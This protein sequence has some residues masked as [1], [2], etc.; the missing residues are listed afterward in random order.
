VQRRDAPCT[1][2]AAYVVENG[3]RGALK[4]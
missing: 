1:T 4:A 3:K 2:L